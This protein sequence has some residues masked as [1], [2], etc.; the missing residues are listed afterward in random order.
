MKTQKIFNRPTQ[1]ILTGIAIIVASAV[2]FLTFAVV[3]VNE[4]QPLIK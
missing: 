1:I 4:I 2:V 3:Y